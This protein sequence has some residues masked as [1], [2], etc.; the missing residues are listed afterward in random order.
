MYGP[1]HRFDDGAAGAETARGWLEAGL[2]CPLGGTHLFR[3]AEAFKL[4][5]AANYQPAQLGVFA[6]AGAKIDDPTA[7]VGDIAARAMLQRPASTSFSSHARI[8]RSLRA[9]QTPV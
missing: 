2:Q 8:S 3:P 6:V 1:V 7:F 5:G 9:A 4:G